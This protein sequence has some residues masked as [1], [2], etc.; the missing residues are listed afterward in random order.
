MLSR[1]K[2]GKLLGPPLQSNSAG[3]RIAEERAE[4]LVMFGEVGKVK[5]PSS[6]PAQ[7][8]EAGLKSTMGSGLAA[9]GAPAQA[10]LNR[11]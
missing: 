1:S 6:Q 10:E 5:K 3:P 9:S 7:G 11:T 2:H 8:P 4:G